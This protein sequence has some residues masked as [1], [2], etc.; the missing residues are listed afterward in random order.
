[1]AMFITG[2]STST[3]S[4]GHM[5][6]YA[7]GPALQIHNLT[8]QTRYQYML[9]NVHAFENAT[10]VIRTDGATNL[11]LSTNSTVALTIDTSQN[12][13]IGTTGPDD[14]LH[15]YGGSSGAS[16]LDSN[17]RLII[18]DD[19][20]AH[21]LFVTPKT[22]NAGIAFGDVEDAFNGHI[23]YN[24]NTDAS[25]DMTFA[26]DDTNIMTL[27]DG[28]VGIGTTAPDAHL[29]VSSS[30]GSATAS[31]HIEGSGSSVVAVDGTQGRLFSV[32]DEMSGSIFSANTIAEIGRAH[33]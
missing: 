23:T 21:L 27:R 33:V 28:N 4:L 17:A 10:G 18:E 13:G 29:H 9:Q 8:N 32:T 16:G 6:L 19:S 30:V 20:H 26:V 14:L 2:S 11:Q 12:V 3:G 1:M 5:E 15:I 24:H 7:T 25:P 31:L 22:T